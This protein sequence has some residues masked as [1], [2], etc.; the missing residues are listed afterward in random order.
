MGGFDPIMVPGLRYRNCPLRL[1]MILL[2]DR[3]QGARTA[4]NPRVFQYIP[5]SALLFTLLTA[6]RD[7]S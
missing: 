5:V 3:D 2:R 6:S 1:F 7:K 4:R